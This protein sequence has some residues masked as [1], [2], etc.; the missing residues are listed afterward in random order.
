MVESKDKDSLGGLNFLE[1]TPGQAEIEQILLSLDKYISVL[2]I[3]GIG[4]MPMVRDG[5]RD[6]IVD[7][8]T[9]QVRIQMW[10]VL[11]AGCIA[12]PYGYARAVVRTAL[13]Q[14][15]RSL[16]DQARE[17][18]LLYNDHGELYVHG[19]PSY[20][21]QDPA[22]M[23]EERFALDIARIAYYIQKF[24]RKQQEAIISILRDALLSADSM[25]VYDTTSF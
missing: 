17:L 14:L 20:E 23:L 5:L 3:N 25:A 18:P 8:V 10:H 9:Q 22:L 11:Q 7:E 13:A 6:L 2:V 1:T 21:M 24:P 19:E 12:H 15:Y 4:R 16:L